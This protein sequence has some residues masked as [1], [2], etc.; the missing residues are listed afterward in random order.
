M[1]LDNRAWHKGRRWSSLLVLSLIWLWSLDASALTIS[2]GNLGD[3]HWTTADSPVIVEGDATLE[4]WATLTIDAGV[5]VQFATTDAGASGRDTS[6]VELTINGTIDVNGTASKPVVFESQAGSAGDWYGIFLTTSVSSASFEHAQIGHAQYGIWSE[7]ANTTLETNAVVIHDASTAGLYINSG[8]P[9]LSGVEARACG[10]YG[11]YVGAAASATIERALVHQNGTGIH[12][13]IDNRTSS[14]THIEY[15]TVW[16]NTGDGIYLGGDDYTDYDVWVRN[17][18]VVTNGG[19][20]ILEDS[21]GA[22]IWVYDSLVWDNSGAGKFDT[23]TKGY[24][25]ENPLFV[26]STNPRLT[27]NSPARFASDTGTDIGALPYQGDPTPGLY[28]VLWKDTTFDAAGSPYLIEGDLRVGPGATLTI[29]AGAELQM[30]DDDKMDVDH[31]YQSVALQV[32]GTLVLNG[33]AA[34]PVHLHNGPTNSAGWEGVIVREGGTATLSHAIVTDATFGVA[35]HSQSTLTVTSSEFSQN[36]Y[37]FWLTRGVAELD[38]V[39]ISNNGGDGIKGDENARLEATNLLVFGNKTGVNVSLDSYA[40]NSPTL[41]SSTID[42]NSED[43]VIVTKSGRSAAPLEI[44]NCIITN[45]G[46]YGVAPGWAASGSDITITHSNVW[47]NGSTNYLHA[48]PGTGCISQNP[49]FV[50]AAGDYSLAQFSPC[51]DTGGST[52]APDHDFTRHNRPADGDG[53]GSAAYDMGAFEFGAS[54]SCGDGTRDAAEECDD[55]N[56][57]AGDGCDSLCNTE[58]GWSCSGQ[59]SSCAEVCGDGH[60]TSSEDCDD[61]NTT[62]GDGCSASCTLEGGYTCSGQ[63]SSCTSECGDS[64]LAA[65]EGCDDGNTDD[66]DG[67]SATCT[68][69]S[70]YQCSGEP[71]SCSDTTICGDGTLSTADGEMCDDANTAAGD[72]CSASCA[73]EEGWNCSGEPSTC[74]EQCGDGVV[75]ASEECDDGDLSNTNGCLNDCTLPNCG[76]GYLQPGEACDDGNDNNG[77]DCLDSC[78]NASCGDGF[79]QEGVEECDDQNGDNTD[80]CLVSCEAAICGDGYI[81]TGV[82]ECDDGN[83]HDDDGCSASCTLEGGGDTGLADAGSDIGIGDAGTSDTGMSDAGTSDAGTSDTG[84]SDSV[85]E[86]DGGTDAGFGD[87]NTGASLHPGGGNTNTDKGCGCSS[88]SDTPQPGSGVYLVI[89][90]LG[91][92]T[93]RRRG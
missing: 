30:T 22:Q 67:C 24:L 25:K 28:G 87:T 54:S 36:G 90:A 18:I 52:G 72:G 42:G 88:A 38:G 92:G 17:S 55:G 82:E 65:G 78:R 37:G 51:I 5:E 47:G 69:E 11:I 58:S 77:D 49:Q 23:N 81:Q 12:L 6:A 56:A 31:S 26:S 35:H 27:E 9:N 68:V 76:D 84:T 40:S 14:D 16:N 46:R 4:N 57:T 7:A 50:S 64:L 53:D 2:G 10:T 3:Q 75:T 34:S 62:A 70:G 91:L 71:S 33:S 66:G 74:A 86:I 60:I 85:G 93:L 8:T 59:P 15:S 48:S 29:E 43:G 32:E 63:P 44:I 21:V 41:H 83:T 19:G 80:A 89:I 61:A 1:D 45:N 13:V 20:G 79:V 73:V 39:K